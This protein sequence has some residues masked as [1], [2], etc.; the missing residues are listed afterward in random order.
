VEPSSDLPTDVVKNT[1]QVQAAPV[2]RRLAESLVAFREVF[3]NRNLR[4][5]QLA[6]MGSVAG[7]YSFGIAIAVYAYRHGGAGA[8]GA[9]AVARTIPAAILAPFVSAAGDRYRQERV[10][11]AADILRALFTATM[12]A[13]VF[14]DGPVAL[15]FALSA[16]GPICTTAFHPAQAAL[17]PTL[18]SSPEELTAVNVS[19]STIESV[20]A[21]LG[22]AAGGAVL[23]TWGVGAA[24]L[25]TV[26]TFLWSALLVAG[27]RP[28]RVTKAE[29]VQA[30]RGR[31]QAE[32]LA[33]FRAVLSEPKLRLI[34][35]LYG[36]QTIVA[37]AM[38][39]LVVVAALR[40]LDLGTGGVGWLYAACGIGGVAGAAIA[41]ALVGRQKLAGDFGV[42]LLLWGMPFVLLGV[43]PNTIVAFVMLAVL[44]VGNTLVDVSALTLLQRH[45]PDAVRARVFGVV[46]SLFAATIGLGAIL[47]PVMIALFGIRAALI[48]TGAF[49]PVLAAL[50]WRR[51]ATLDGGVNLPFLELLRRIPIFAPLPALALEGLAGALVP[52][53]LAAGEMLFRSGDPGDRFYVVESGELVIDLATGPKVEGPGGWVGEVALLRDVPRT[54]TVRAQTDVDL[55]A[56]ERE[57]FLAA[58]TGHAAAN[59]IAGDIV[60]ERL[61]LSPV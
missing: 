60:F 50:F 8:V 7:Q 49:L 3:R 32:A 2:R 44:G 15:V 51:L 41:L 53:H 45:A 59:D 12:A 13:L 48:M 56:L 17:L 47:A 9:V 52:V 18:A 20:S 22:P 10:M 39:V 42:G 54:A 14:A 58:V 11:L 21:F 16:F 5:L 55:L 30:P 35:G 28:Q 25:L 29:E 1:T 36:A 23:A 43:W 24:L 27:V 31:W 34:V 26:A 4:R 40:L 6:W 57:N 38:G 61:A 19:S 37:G 33:G 46:E